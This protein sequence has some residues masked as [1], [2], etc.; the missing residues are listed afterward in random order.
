[1]TDDTNHGERRGWHIG[2]HIDPSTIIAA[3]VFAVSMFAS[4]SHF[5][6]R[7]T[8]LEEQSKAQAAITND[9]REGVRALADEVKVE[10][11]GLRADLMQYLRTGR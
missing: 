9:T 4:I 10:I 3:A 11:R 5:D 6:R 1:M 8:V 2:K 7:V